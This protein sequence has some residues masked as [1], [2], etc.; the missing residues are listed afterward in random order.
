MTA[1][2]HTIIH[3]IRPVLPGRAMRIEAWLL[4]AT[5]ALIR[6]TADNLK[7]AETIMASGNGSNSQSGH[8]FIAIARATHQLT[9][10]RVHPSRKRLQHQKDNNYGIHYGLWMIASTLSL[11]RIHCEMRW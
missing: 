2:L 1:A 7:L 3:P 11:Y 10:I 4:R 6:D 8:V 9:I 5:D